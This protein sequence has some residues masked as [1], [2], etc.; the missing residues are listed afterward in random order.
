M[1]HLADTPM[2]NADVHTPGSDAKKTVLKILI[3]LSTNRDGAARLGRSTIMGSSVCCADINTCLTVENCSKGC[4][5]CAQHELGF[6]GN[7]MGD[8]ERFFFFPGVGNLARFVLGARFWNRGPF[9]SITIKIKK[10]PFI[11]PSRS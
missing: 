5:N 4:I 9:L 8:S 2:R 1:L 10:R 7:Y 6:R 11:T 3:K